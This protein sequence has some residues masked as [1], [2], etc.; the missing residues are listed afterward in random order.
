MSGSKGFVCSILGILKLENMW[1]AAET[2]IWPLVI[3]EKNNFCA[4][5]KRKQA[6]R[7]RENF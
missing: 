2:V 7:W 6:Q 3:R 5:L 1:S 4:L